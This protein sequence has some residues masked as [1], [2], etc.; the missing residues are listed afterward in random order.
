ML[1]ILGGAS[2]SGKSITA[3]R[4]VIEKQTPFF[5][6]DFLITS[7]QEIPSLE[8]KHGLPFISKAE[9]LWPLINPMLIGLMHD[10][11]TYLIEG[12]G[13]LPKNIAKLRSEFPNDVRACFV[14]YSEISPSEKFKTVREMG[15]NMDDWTTKISDDDLIK[16]IEDM[17]EFSKYLKSE[18]NKLNIAY[19]DSS[20]NFVQYLENVFQYLVG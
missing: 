11:P 20:K 1:Y 16:A 14:G 3:R 4:F 15:G 19:F 13:L 8:I 10:E 9:K 18:C 7:L 17:I 12:D 5:C 2:R 6:V